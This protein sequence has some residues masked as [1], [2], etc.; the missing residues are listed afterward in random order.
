ML[1]MLI[2]KQAKNALS[3]K[4]CGRQP[5]KNLKRYGLLKRLSS[6]NCTWSIL[7]YFDSVYQESSITAGRGF[8]G[9]IDS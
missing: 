4:I 3:N 1:K 8:F 9:R 7:G 5:Y 6:T 2:I